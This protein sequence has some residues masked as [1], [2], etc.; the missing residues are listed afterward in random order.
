MSRRPAVPVTISTFDTFQRLMTSHTMLFLV[1][2]SLLSLFQGVLSVKST[3][4]EYN[5]TWVH[6]NPDGRFDR[7]VM[8]ING[9]WPIP[10][11]EVNKGERMVVTVRNQLGNE[12]T[13]VHWHGLYQNGTAHMDGPPGVTQCEIPHD[14]YF[15]YDFVVCYYSLSGQILPHLTMT[16]G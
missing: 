4:L 5:I 3:F 10:A 15:V 8:G 16:V 7:P 2:S 1:L 13:S 11:L 14:D 6:R 9:Q 12:T